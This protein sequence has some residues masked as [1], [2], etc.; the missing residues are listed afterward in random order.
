MEEQIL[1]ILIKYKTQKKIYDIADPEER[2]AK[3]ITSMVMEFIEW[4]DFGTHDFYLNAEE[5]QTGYY[6]EGSHTIYTIEEVYNHW[7]TNVKK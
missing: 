4:L 7:L 2:S 1:K 3:E 5:G 6:Q